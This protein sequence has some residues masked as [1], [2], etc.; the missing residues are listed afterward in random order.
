MAALDLLITV[1]LQYMYTCIVGRESTLTASWVVV[2]ETALRRIYAFRVYPR[3]TLWIPE[4]LMLCNVVI[5]TTVVF[6]PTNVV[7][8]N[9]TLYPFL[10]V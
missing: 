10:Q 1:H 5:D 7:S 3:D 6:T 2:L 9:Q 8:I 4:S